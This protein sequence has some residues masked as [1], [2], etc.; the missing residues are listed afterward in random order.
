MN[1]AE[2]IFIESTLERGG[3]HLYSK[4]NA[5]AFVLACREEKIRLLGIDGFWLTANSIQPSME[6]SVDF[7]LQFL[8]EI[9]MKKRSVF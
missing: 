3:I 2:R 1:K 8:Q 4:E 5:I 7:S 9:A 6:D